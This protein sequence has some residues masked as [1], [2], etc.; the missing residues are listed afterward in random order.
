MGEVYRAKDTKLGR[1]VALKVLPASFTSDPERV[2]RFRREAQVLA[3][4]NHPH[5]AQ[6]YG[7]ED[8]NSMQFL[9]L[10]LVDGES[11]DKRI[12]RGGIPLD[13]ALAIATQITEALEAAHEKGII[14]RDLKPANIALS[15]D[16]LVKVLD[17]GLAKAVE[18]TSSGSDPSMSLTITSPAMMTGV[19]V[20]LGT[21]AYMS[22]EQAKGRTADRRSDIWSFGCVLYEMLTAQRAFDGEDVSETLAT[23]LRGEPQW[24]SLPPTLPAPVTRLLRRCLMKDRRRRLADIADARLDLDEA[25][26]A[27]VEPSSAN[28]QKRNPVWLA[29][30]GIA[31]AVAIAL[32]VFVTRAPTAT[33]PRVMRLSIAASGRPVN[34][35]HD[36]AITPDGSRVVYVGENGN[37]IYVRALDQLEPTVLSDVGHPRDLFVSPD[38]RWIGFFDGTMLK[39]VPI[40]GGPAL[41]VSKSLLASRGATWTDDDSIIL[42]TGQNS[43]GLRRVSAS[44]ETTVVTTP[45]REQGETY[46]YWPRYLP[47]RRAVLFTVAGANGAADQVAVLD[48]QSGSKKTLI[49]GASD[50]RYV[51]SGH[52]VYIANGTR[53][54][55]GRASTL[56]AVPFDL[57]RLETRGTPIAIVPRVLTNVWGGGQFDVALD[58]T[59][60]YFPGGQQTSTRTLAWVDRQGHETPIN[61]PARPYTYPRISPDGTR[62]AL[63]V[64]DQEQDIWV[65]S[66]LR[67]TLTRVTFSPGQDRFPVWTP[68][69]RRLIFRSDRDGSPNMFWQAADGTGT[70]ERLLPPSGHIE[71]PYTISPDATRI[72]FRNQTTTGGALDLSLLILDATRRVQP[73]LHTGADQQNAEISPDGRWLAYESTVSGQSEIYV[74]PFPDVNAGQWQVSTSGGTRPL[75]ARSGRELFYVTPTDALMAVAIEPGVAW[76]SHAARQMFQGLYYFAHEDANTGRTYDIAPDGQRFLMIKRDVATDQTPSPSTGIVAVLN[77]VEELKARVPAPR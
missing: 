56:W 48:L 50:A 55:S 46:H 70:A 40:T 45:N 77:W 15:K 51:P 3:S 38:G 32:A 57:Q 63:D 11:L 60:V 18:T 72:V 71:T 41:P 14:H 36:I 47:G 21:A 64:R 20:I 67:E 5:I 59:L 75:W 9:V 19:G 26:A 29:I 69:S 17:F 52:L 58:G 8:A 22:P 10:E 73:L 49:R 74:R 24:A 42:A 65:W 28:D 30:G 68:D 66:F 37:E 53:D 44:G 33:P 35:T 27:P 25:M 31:A 1:D 16:G 62:V 61:A 2:A 6:I 43:F 7:V 23:I 4:L 54:A 12:A 39:K 76:M 13:E 34:F